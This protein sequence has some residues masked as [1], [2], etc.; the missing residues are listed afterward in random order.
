M[1]QSVL[2]REALG[3]LEGELR[4]AQAALAAKQAEL[5]ALLQGATAREEKLM[6]VGAG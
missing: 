1:R 5:Q 4:A 2:H 6:Q 3:R